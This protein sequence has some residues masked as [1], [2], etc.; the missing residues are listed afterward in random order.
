MMHRDA[1]WSALMRFR[2]RLFDTV[3]GSL[4][5]AAKKHSSRKGTP[6]AALLQMGT[7]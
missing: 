2:H 4:K 7:Y 1:L 5:E 6:K 3:F